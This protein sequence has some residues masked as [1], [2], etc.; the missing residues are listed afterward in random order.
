MLSAR[1][2]FFKRVYTYFPQKGS[3]LRGA[4]QIRGVVLRL[5]I[6]TPRKPNSAR[7]PVVKSF[8]TTKVYTLAY[9]PGIG[10]SLRRNSRVLIRGGGA[11]DVPVVNYSCCRGVYDLSGVLNRRTRRSIYGVKRNPEEV[12][13]IRRKFRAL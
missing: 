3:K 9:I 7:R 5:R 12:S 11:R 4:P 6:C 10:H 1:Q 8:L 13:F 2:A